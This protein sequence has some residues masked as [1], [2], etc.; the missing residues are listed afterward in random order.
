MS[1][2]LEMRDVGRRDR[3]C[4]VKDV[5]RRSQGLLGRRAVKS[6]KVSESIAG[7]SLVQC[8]RRKT[9]G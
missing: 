5:M 7:V 2:R 4:G 6:H 9:S 1:A 8:G 3:R